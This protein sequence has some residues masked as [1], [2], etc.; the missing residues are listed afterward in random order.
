[1]NVRSEN[2]LIQPDPDRTAD[3]GVILGN[4]YTSCD[5]GVLPVDE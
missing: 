1:L 4:N 2:I 3:F 5:A